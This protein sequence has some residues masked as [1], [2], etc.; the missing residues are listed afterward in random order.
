M[1]QVT[2]LACRRGLLC[3]AGSVLFWM[4]RHSYCYREGVTFK[5]TF[6]SCN[7]QIRAAGLFTLTDL[8]H[9]CGVGW[10]H[11]K[12]C[13]FA[14]LKYSIVVDH[15]GPAVSQGIESYFSWL[16]MWVSVVASNVLSL[17][18]TFIHSV[19]ETKPNQTLLPP[20]SCIPTHILS[21]S[22]P[23]LPFKALI[24]LLSTALRS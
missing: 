11:S 7:D 13:L 17:C 1:E 3:S 14:T 22:F 18:P 10:G 8:Y 16:W 15:N 9:L 4:D 21:P 20:C 6:T 23:L 5:S 12:P 19:M 24:S 2:E